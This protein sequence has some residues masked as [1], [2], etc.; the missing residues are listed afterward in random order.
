MRC[1]KIIGFLLTTAGFTVRAN[2]SLGRMR[3]RSGI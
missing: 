2:A 3:A 1:F